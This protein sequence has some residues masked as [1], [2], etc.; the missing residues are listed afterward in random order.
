VVN[1][2]RKYGEHI[3]AR[4]SDAGSLIARRE[5]PTEMTGRRTQ[6]AGRALSGC[7]VQRD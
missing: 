3:L 5:R 7:M 6:N 2:L 1:M 4:Y